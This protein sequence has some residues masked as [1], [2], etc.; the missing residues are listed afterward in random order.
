MGVIV[1][2]VPSSDS[3]QVRV[4]T[5][6]AWCQINSKWI[7]GTRTVESANTHL[8]NFILTKNM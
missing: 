7:V 3:A 4:L 1:A 2:I 8:R 6:F 5:H